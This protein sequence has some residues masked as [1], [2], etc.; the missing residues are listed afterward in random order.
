MSARDR[1]VGRFEELAEDEPFPGVHRRAFDSQRATVTAYEFE[2][3]AEFPLHRHPQEQITLVEEGT[4]VFT[5]GGEA[6][7]LQPGGWSIVEPNV[8]HGLRAGAEGARILAVIV[9]RREGANAYE[10]LED[11]DES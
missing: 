9:P 11:Q 10:V 8:E 1:L 4:I 7:E 6:T 5:V 2:P 3:G